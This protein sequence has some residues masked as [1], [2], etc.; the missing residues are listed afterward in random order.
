[1]ILLLKE[2]L[3]LILR[4]VSNNIVNTINYM[5]LILMSVL[6]VRRTRDFNLMELTTVVLISL[7]TLILSLELIKTFN[8]FF[9]VTDVKTLMIFLSSITT[10][11]VVITP[12]LNSI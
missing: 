2:E 6:L 1:M 12:S 4:P 8:L 11:L 7:V 10:R 5:Q 9:L 3:I